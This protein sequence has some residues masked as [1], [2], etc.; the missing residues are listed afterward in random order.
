MRDPPPILRRDQ[1]GVPFLSAATLSPGAAERNQVGEGC[2]EVRSPVVLERPGRLTLM[3]V[4]AVLKASP[5]PLAHL[6]FRALV[7]RLQRR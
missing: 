4:E 7:R 3:R 5:I 6:A 1:E 2:Q